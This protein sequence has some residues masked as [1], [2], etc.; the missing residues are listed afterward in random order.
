[1]SN[2]YY[3]E[4]RDR[5]LAKNR[6]WRKN[7]KERIRENKR[8][9]ESHPDRKAKK[10]E[11]SAKEYL[12][13]REKVLARQANRRRG[14]RDFLDEVCMRYGCQNP[15]C[16]WQ[17]SFKA[18]QLT[19]HHYD[20]SKKV[21]EVAKMESWGYD[22]IVEEVNKCVVLCRNCHPMADKGDIMLNEAMLCKVSVKAI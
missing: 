10:R 21:I 16:N 2:Q 6:E 3:L 17:G 18:Y 15:S 8:I 9:Y 4:N 13:N 20:P 1:M 22:K 14:R 12:L 7:N 5:I 11:K 19:F